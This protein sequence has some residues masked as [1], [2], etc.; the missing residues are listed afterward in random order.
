MSD[1][2]DARRADAEFMGRLKANIAKHKPT[3]DALARAG[4]CNRCVMEPYGCVD[5]RDPTAPKDTE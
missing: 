2:I 5:H 3:L 4:D 1:F